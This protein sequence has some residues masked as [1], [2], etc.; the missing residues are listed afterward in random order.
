MKDICGGWK[1]ATKTLA[2]RE[3]LDNNWIPLPCTTVDPG[4]LFVNLANLSAEPRWVPG[5]DNEAIRRLND[6]ILGEQR[7][8]GWSDHDVV[9]CLKEGES[10]A[11]GVVE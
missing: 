3:G 9:N 10:D 11:E 8:A 5:T 6:F 1:S 7:G 2:A 4:I